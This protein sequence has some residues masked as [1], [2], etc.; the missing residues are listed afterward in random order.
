MRHATRE[1][2]CVVTML[3]CGIAAL[4]AQQPDT[5]RTAML[6]GLVRDSS[7]FRSPTRK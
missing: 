5:A 2:L 4:G 7:G 6:T 1:T 3:L